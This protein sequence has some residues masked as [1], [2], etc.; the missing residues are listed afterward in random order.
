MQDDDKTVKTQC[1]NPCSSSG[2]WNH[3]CTSELVQ[4][5]FAMAA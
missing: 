2:E 5:D 4:D 1:G 3:S